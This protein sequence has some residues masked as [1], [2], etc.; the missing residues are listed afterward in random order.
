MKEKIKNKFLDK[1]ESSINDAIDTAKEVIDETFKIKLKVK[2][3]S[4]NELPKF[5]THGASGFDLR[6]F[7]KGPLVLEPGEF[8]LIPTGLYFEIP[9]GLE[10]QVR[11]RSGLALKKGITVLNSP[12]TIDH[13]YRGECG[14]ILINHSKNPFEINNGDRIAQGVLATVLTKSLVNI[15]EVDEINKETD[16]NS[17][18]FGTTG[19]K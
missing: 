15:I 5:E 18:G 11:P 3:E 10:I 12:G 9:S 1:L 4:N 2:N 19:T 6:A 13:D 8:K 16:R 17:S 14:V 7:L